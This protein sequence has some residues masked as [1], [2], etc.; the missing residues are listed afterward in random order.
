MSNIVES[1]EPA[2]FYVFVDPTD[3]LVRHQVG[4]IGS[5][6]SIPPDETGETL[7]FLPNPKYQGFIAPFQNNL[8]RNYRAE[9]NLELT[10]QRYYPEYPSRLN[11]IFLLWTKENADKYQVRHP[12]HV[13]HRVLKKVRSTGGY[14]YSL[15]DSAWVNFLRLNHSMDQDT[16]KFVTDM[17][18]GGGFVCHQKLES[19]GH[20]WTDE[21]IMEALFLGRIEFYDRTLPPAPGT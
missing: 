9:Y 4:L 6:S 11:S 2:D 10:R 8:V 20:P 12:E 21:P 1:S 15:H 17:Y 13:A 14:R 18:W 16:V 19:M 7:M 3:W 5:F